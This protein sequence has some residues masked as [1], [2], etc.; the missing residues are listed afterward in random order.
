MLDKLIKF[1]D[2]NKNRDNN[3]ITFQLAEAKEIADLLIERLEEKINTLKELELSVDKKIAIIERLLQRAD[4]IKIPSLA[5]TDRYEEILY[6]KN[7]GFKIEEIAKL[8][9]IPAGEVE[10][11]LNLKN[12]QLQANLSR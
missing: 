8:L 10:L 1:K 3:L 7:K 12:N 6:L 2:R 5:R 4:S 11:F 9:D